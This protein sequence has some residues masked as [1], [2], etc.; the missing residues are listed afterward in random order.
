MRDFG[1]DLRNPDLAR[2]AEAMGAKG[3]RVEDPSEVKPALERALAE[4]GPFLLDVRTNPSELSHA[5]E[6]PA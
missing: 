2:V 3:V 1:T 4:D 5:S 6:G